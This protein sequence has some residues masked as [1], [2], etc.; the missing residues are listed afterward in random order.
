MRL[1]KER[2]AIAFLLTAPPLVV[3]CHGLA[4]LSASFTA[5]AIQN[6]AAWLGAA[7][8]GCLLLVCGAWRAARRGLHAALLGMGTF[9]CVAIFLVVLDR[10]GPAGA[11]AMLIVGPTAS[12]AGWRVAQGLPAWLDGFARRRPMVSA[13]WT[14]IA[15]AAVV[16]TGRLSIYMAD[17]SNEFVLTTRNTFWCGHMCLPAYLYGAELAANGEEN[18]YDARHYPGLNPNATPE[19]VL[20]GMPVEDPYQ[21][22]PQFLLLPRLAIAVSHN[23]DLIRTVWFAVQALCVVALAVAVIRWIGGR[24]GEVALLLLPAVFLAMPTLYNFQYGQF[25][26]LAMLL[27][28][29]GMVGIHAG[30]NGL[31]GCLLSSAILAKLFPAFLLVPLLL[32][33]R[34]RALSWVGGFAV[35][36]TGLTWLVLGSEPFTA[37]VTY[38]LPRLRDGGAFAFEEAWPE[39]RELIIIANLAPGAVVRKLGELGLPGMTMGLVSQVQTAY[40]LVIV[41][42]AFL[43]ARAGGSRM[44]RV[45]GWLALLNLASLTSPGAWGDY[46]PAASVLMVTLWIAERGTRGLRIMPLL[47]VGFVLMFLPGVIPYG[48]PST[49]PV[50]LLLSLM[51]AGV[52]VGIN[53]LCVWRAVR[54]SAP[55]EAPAME[56]QPAPRA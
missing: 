53:V 23:F 47:V 12:F 45:C 17:R 54:R 4:A 24:A 1:S 19:T 55:A 15:L 32:Q 34:F 8:A 2:L 43:V 48:E 30:R 21:Y 25:H 49:G 38:H 36:V 51:C 56:P 16:Q 10:I 31:G 3:V 33:R 11:L 14:V 6:E 37:F 52:L 5:T 46:V 26:L 28:L 40:T 42:M 35:A 41:A 27:A 13:A 44:T 50:T 22:P 18:L 20:S 29:A 9:L 7:S 39:L